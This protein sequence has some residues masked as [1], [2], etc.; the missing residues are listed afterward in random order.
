MRDYFI[1]VDKIITTDLIKLKHE[2][3][4]F[5]AV[6]LFV[7]IHI[8]WLLLRIMFPWLIPFITEEEA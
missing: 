8:T 1:R 6:L 2:V 4:A 5:M 3:G 7:P